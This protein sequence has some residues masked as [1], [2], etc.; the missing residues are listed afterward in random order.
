MRNIGEYFQDDEGQATD[1]SDL[2]VS[3]DGTYPPHPRAEF[4]LGVEETEESNN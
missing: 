4:R 3:E 2:E 1:H